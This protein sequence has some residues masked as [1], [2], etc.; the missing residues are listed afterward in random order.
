MLDMGGEGCM[1]LGT[2][3]PIVKPAVP[4]DARMRLLNANANEHPLKIKLSAH[5]RTG[6]ITEP[7]RNKVCGSDVHKCFLIATIRSRDGNRDSKL[8]KFFLRIQAKKG[9]KVAA[10]ALARKVLCILHHLLV[11]QCTWKKR[12]R[13]IRGRSGQYHHPP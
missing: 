2:Q 1:L 3:I 4:A 7:Q 11:N 5:I 8:K 10:A 6:I 13:R 9:S 12:I